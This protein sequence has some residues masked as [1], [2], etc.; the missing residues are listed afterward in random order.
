MRTIARLISLLEPSSQIESAYIYYK[1]EKDA[2]TLPP[3]TGNEFFECGLKKD[4]VDDPSW[5]G[6][7]KVQRPQPGE[8][9][10]RSFMKK[11]L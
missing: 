5:L 2:R 3:R 4:V 9:I 6:A 1:W 7:V 11:E 8:P 10:V